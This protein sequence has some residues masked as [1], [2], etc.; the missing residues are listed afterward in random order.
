MS[1]VEDGNNLMKYEVEQKITPTQEKVES[2][3]W[4]YN[5]ACGVLH[6]VQ[7]LIALIMSLVL[8]KNKAFKLPMTT[9]FLKWELYP[10]QDLVTQGTLKFGIATSLFAFMSSIAHVIVLFNFKRYISDLRKGANYFR[11]YEY[12][13]SSSLMI[14]LIGALFGIYDIMTQINMMSVNCCMNLFGLLH[15]ELN[16]GRKPS[17]LNW[18]P[19]IYGCFAGLVPWITIFVYFSQSASADMPAFVYAVLFTYLIFF[20][21]FPINMYCQYKQIGNWNDA[22][23]PDQI[24]GGYFYGEKLY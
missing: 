5:L 13:V 21:T 8:E 15:E 4:R 14:G 6:F 9:L 18:L 1:K 24:K 23:Y 17:E 22:K 3:L 7:G 12:A 19:F 20:N 2:S 16:M 11:W 10:V